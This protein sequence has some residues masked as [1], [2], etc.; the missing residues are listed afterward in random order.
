MV[1]L[2]RRQRLHTL[3]VSCILDFGRD[4]RA[5]RTSGL[6]YH[7]HAL[8]NC[9]RANVFDHPTGVAGV[10]TPPQSNLGFDDS[11]QLL[12][13]DQ[14]LSE[15]MLSSYIDQWSAH[16]IDRSEVVVDIQ[17]FDFDAQQV[18][19]GVLSHR[20]SQRPRGHRPG[21]LSR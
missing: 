18:A 21:N 15:A 7:C 5:L 20:V 13:L 17:R 2:L 19:L 8:L 6:V 14:D 3:H 9:Y 12:H 10:R 1:H 4:L 11:V 16:R